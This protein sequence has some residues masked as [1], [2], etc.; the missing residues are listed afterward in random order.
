MTELKPCPFCGSEDIRE[1]SGYPL[2][3]WIVKCKHCGAKICVYG[4]HQQAVSFWNRR[5]NHEL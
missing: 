2:H 5:T 3:Y 1:H 4:S